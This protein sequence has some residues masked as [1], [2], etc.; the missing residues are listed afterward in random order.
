MKAIIS[1]RRQGSEAAGAF[2]WT[3]RRP[4]C[5][6]GCRHLGSFSVT[7]H[8]GRVAGTESL[9]G[10]LTLIESRHL[11]QHDAARD[12]TGLDQTPQ[13]DELAA[14]CARASDH[15]F[16]LPT[17]GAS[18]RLLN[19]AARALLASDAA[20]S[21]RASS[22]IPRRT[23][24]MPA[25]ERPLLSSPRA[26]L[27]GGTRE[28]GDA[29]DGSTVAQVACEHFAAR[30][31]RRFRCRCRRPWSGFAPSTRLGCPLSWSGRPGPR[32]A[33][34]PP[35]ARRVS[36][37]SGFVPALGA[38]LI[39]SSRARSVAFICART[40]G[41]TGRARLFISRSVLGADRLPFGGK[42][43]PRDHPERIASF[44]LEIPDAEPHQRRLPAQVDRARALTGEGFVFAAR[45]PASLLRECRHRRHPTVAGL[46]AEPAEKGPH[47]ERRIEAVQVFARLCSRDTAMLVGW[48]TLDVDSVP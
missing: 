24:W 34:P 39:R 33:S 36:R 21:A 30:A 18:T 1:L 41:Q 37:G 27:V 40:E 17:P 11:A 48:M 38:S 19:H 45:P 23:R 16:L 43:R 31:Y 9:E 10:L 3:A 15:C 25:F 6:P 46:A 22:I 47:Q 44:G 13:R 7:D 20:G 5:V 12:L 29:G 32:R 8:L 14:F 26:A 42:Q 35:R 28:A 2:L 4:G